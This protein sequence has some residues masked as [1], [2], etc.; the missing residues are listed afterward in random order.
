M[1]NE[2]LFDNVI[3]YDIIYVYV[4]CD[5]LLVLSVCRDNSMVLKLFWL[6]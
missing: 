6:G 2:L 4:L 1:R 3:N 5:M